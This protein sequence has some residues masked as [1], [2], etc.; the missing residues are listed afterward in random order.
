M[1]L[2]RSIGEVLL[3][4]TIIF[5]SFHIKKKKLLQDCFCV[6]F[7]YCRI[8]CPVGLNCDQ[9]K[10]EGNTVSIQWRIT[11]EHTCP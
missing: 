10:R 2:I 6:P 3:Y 11:L 4:F 5:F 7:L 8:T 1:I 9:W